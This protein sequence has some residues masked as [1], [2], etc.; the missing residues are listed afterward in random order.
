MWT[1]PHR[2]NSADSVA[3]NSVACEPITGALRRFRIGNGRNL[4]A[5]SFVRAKL[6]STDGASRESM[7]NRI[8]LTLPA[9]ENSSMFHKVSM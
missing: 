4:S 3:T 8:E 5:W 7:S 2:A 1:I 9:L 6:R